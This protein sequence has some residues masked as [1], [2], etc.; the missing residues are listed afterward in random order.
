MLQLLK[1]LTQEVHF[2]YASRPMSLESL[3]QVRRLYTGHRI[4]VKVTEVKEE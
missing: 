3:G 4:K 1:A 2:W